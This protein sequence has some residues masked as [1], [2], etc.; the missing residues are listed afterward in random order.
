MTD[1]KKIDELIRSFEGESIPEKVLESIA[2]M[3]IEDQIE[4]ENCSVYLNYRILQDLY[5]ICK[6]T[7][8]IQDVSRDE[9]VNFISNIQR[10]PNIAVIIAM[11]T[12]KDF[13]KNGYFNFGIETK[14]PCGDS[15]VEMAQF[16]SDPMLLLPST[17]GHYFIQSLLIQTEIAQ[18]KRQLNQGKEYSWEQFI[19][20]LTKNKPL[21]NETLMAFRNALLLMDFKTTTN[22]ERLKEAVS[23]K[24]KY[25][26]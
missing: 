26:E 19:V 8:Q 12:L 14:L 4:L 9:F 13:L 24:F 22:L 5:E 2:Y 20:E 7:E 1:I 10:T 25:N 16:Y 21:W 15:N 3:P 18:Y 6:S 23:K 17:I 11:K